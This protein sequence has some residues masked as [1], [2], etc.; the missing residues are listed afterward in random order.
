MALGKVKD[1]KIA[2]KVLR[3]IDAKGC[4]LEEFNELKKTRDFKKTIAA[5]NK[6]QPA[7]NPVQM[8]QDA[9]HGT[10]SILSTSVDSY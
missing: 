6:V 1:G 5:M 7:N 4:S 9:A 10:P 2:R 8:L 3:R